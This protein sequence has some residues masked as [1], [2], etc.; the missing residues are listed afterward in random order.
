MLI[1]LL[2][3]GAAGTAAMTAAWAGIHVVR[4]AQAHWGVDPTESDR[5][6]P[7]DDLVDGP[8]AIDTRAIDIDAPV[9]AV[10]PWL[11]QMGYGRAGW[12]SYDVFDMDVPSALSVEQRWQSLAIGDI[13]PTHPGGGFEVKV[14]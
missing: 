12:Y 3:L 8:D 11:V 14:L 1:R 13:L 9:E 2:A 10:W 6:M 4:D 7:G 5:M